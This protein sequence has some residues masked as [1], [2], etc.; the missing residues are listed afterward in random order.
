MEPGIERYRKPTRVLHWINA[1]S[2]GILFLTGLVL[3]VPSWGR[4]LRGVGRVS[5]IA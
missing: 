2:F 4:W 3:F 1:V 5:S